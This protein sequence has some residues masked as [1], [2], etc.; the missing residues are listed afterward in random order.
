MNAPARD[1]Y[2]RTRLLQ[3][4]VA[5]LEGEGAMDVM[6]LR[7]P[8]IFGLV[9]G[10]RPLWQFVLDRIAAGTGPVAVLGGT[11]SAVT[12]RQVAQAAVGAMEN[13][14]HGTAYPINGY[15]LSY[16][17]LNQ[18]ACRLLGRDPED[19][20]VVPL[21]AVLPAAVEESLRWCVENPVEA[22]ASAAL[23]PRPPPTNRRWS[24][25]GGTRPAP[26]ASCSAGGT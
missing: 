23:S 9:A 16:V 1:P 15:D 5:F 20:K 7:L 19:V 3:E 10:Q 22:R 24:P 12:A 2:P 21:E 13:G 25:A 18:I 4:Q 8:Y 14:T 17:E 11:T 6:S 26:A